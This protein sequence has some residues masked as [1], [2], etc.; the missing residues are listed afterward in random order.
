MTRDWWISGLINDSVSWI[1]DGVTIILLESGN[2]IEIELNLRTD[3]T[4]SL[5]SLP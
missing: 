4:A 2:Q 1:M 5:P 3:V